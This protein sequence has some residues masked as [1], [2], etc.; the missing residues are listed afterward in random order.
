MLRKLLFILLLLPF[1]VQSQPATIM[2]WNLLSFSTDAGDRVAHFSTV[3]DSLRP[4]LLA[5]QEV[6]GQASASYFHQ[7]VLQEEMAMAPFI[8]GP[9]SEAALFYDEDLF[10]L[11]QVQAIPTALRNINWYTLKRNWSLDTLHVFLV[12]L[13]SS[14]GTE[15]ENQRLAEVN[16][17]R[18][19]T[20][21]LPLNSYFMVCGDFNIYGGDEPAYQRLLEQDGQNG[22]FID[23][24]GINGPWNVASYSQFHTQSPRVRSFGGGASGGLDDRFDMIMFSHSFGPN[25]DIQ[26]MYNTAWAVGN[27]GEH[28]NDS[29][30]A[31]TNSM[32]G[33]S[34]ANALHYASDHLPVVTSFR[35][36][37]PMGV[38]DAEG[39][40]ISV[41]P[42]PSAGLYSVNLSSIKRPI[43]C[44][45][46]D[47][48]GRVADQQFIGR[49]SQLLEI[50][51]SEQPTGVYLLLLQDEMMES[52]SV[53]LLKY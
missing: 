22:Y 7:A 9:D 42:N 49:N 38:E 18:Q 14:S 27:D 6:E 31:G 37:N 12:H 35:F 43:Q 44:T 8:D 17:L 20:D 26:Y 10:E 23:P 53:R 36:M 13:K 11:V 41:T 28:Y 40:S 39:Q 46:Y 5:V 21:Q 32:V 30:N 45:I 1:S 50:D 33:A 24:I 4:Q 52:H 19:V 3:I 16:A 29:I 34:M 48:S 2:T 15:N 47:V 51:I 25:G